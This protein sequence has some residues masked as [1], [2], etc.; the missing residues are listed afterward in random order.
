MVLFRFGCSIYTN[1][2]SDENLA[3]TQGKYTCIKATYNPE[4]PPP[5]KQNRNKLKETHKV[6]IV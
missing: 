3:T 2:S 4:P 1:L 6:T 5:K